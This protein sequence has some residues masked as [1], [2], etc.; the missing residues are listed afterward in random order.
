[1][2]EIDKSKITGLTKEKKAILESYCGK[3][4]SRIDLNK[5]RDWYKYG[6]GSPTPCPICNLHEFTCANSY[7]ICD[8]CKWENCEYQMEFP[9]DDAG[10]NGLSLNDYKVE[11][12]HAK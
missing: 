6:Q 5:V 9:D 4:S 8:V 7:E 2:A 1:M 12:R 11:Y 10:P 3:Y